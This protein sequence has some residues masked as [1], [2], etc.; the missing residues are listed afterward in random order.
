MS[1]I[2]YLNDYKL[3]KCLGEGSFGKVYLTKK[4]NNQKVYAT[5][6]LDITKA[7][8]QDMKKYLNNEIKIMQELKENENIIYLQELIKTEHHLY[9]IM[10]YCNGGSLLA[11]LNNY[12]M[13][14]G[15][16]FSQEIVQYFMGQI[17][18]GLKYIHSKNIIHRDIK[19]DN[20]LLNFDNI[21]D[22]KNFNLLNSKIK[23]ID[24]GLA[25]KYKGQTI[26]GSPLYM[27]PLIL[28]KYNKAGGQEKLQIYDQ[29][30]DIWSLGALC[31]EMVVGEPLFNVDNLQQL[32]EKVEQG[33]YTI[34]VYFDFSKELISFINSMLQYE[35]NKRLSAEQLYKHPFL[36]K[37]IKDFSKADYE[38]ISYKINNGQLMINIKENKTVWRI[39]NNDE[40][41]TKIKNKEY[42]IIEPIRMQKN[43]ENNIINSENNLIKLNTKK[44]YSTISPDDNRFVEGY[45][46]PRGNR[47]RKNINFVNKEKEQKEFENIKDSINIFEEQEK[48]KKENNSK[49]IDIKRNNN[50]KED[51]QN[52]MSGLLIEYN[53]AKKYFRENNLKAQEE[54]A[55]IE[56]LKIQNIKK[57]YELGYSIYLNDLPKPISPEYIYG[58]S[59]VERNNKFNEVINKYKKDRNKLMSK[60]KYY[61]KYIMSIKIKEEF[62]KCKKILENLN[63]IIKNLEIRFKNEWTPSPLFKI[64]FQKYQVEKISFNNCIFKL[65]IE[66]K[67][68]DNKNEDINF[69]I[70]LIINEKKILSNNIKLKNID[71]YHEEC[72]WSMKYND[73]KNIDNNVENFIFVVENDKNSSYIPYKAKINISRVKKGKS[74]SFNVKIPTNNNEI[75]LI[76]FTAFP[77]IPKGTKYLEIEERE[78]LI[79]KNIY[80]PFEGKSHL[81]SNPPKLP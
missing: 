30:A 58:Y 6:I 61:Q 63:Y 17:V 22:F 62:E 70:S 8:T 55:N 67:K 11:L 25:T 14:Y 26:A 39:F 4:V 51:W 76:N 9:I 72:L 1:Q 44:E 18:N 27:D 50:Q 81:T 3:I 46:S 59:T 5:K 2:K 35:P 24:F 37:N 53:E 15:K 64:E 52:Y 40:Q 13:K 41:K 20:I 16:P 60:M 29:T 36:T 66:M 57:Q 12:K 34:P 28:K 47:K 56:L 31:Y 23:I 74:I 71:N 75:K 78:F 54:N 77:I 79:I 42:K 45:A 49:E 33:D 38:K 69:I 43:I 10:E 48:E 80:T 21:E 65:K 73:W 19:L 32:I 7:N 68:I